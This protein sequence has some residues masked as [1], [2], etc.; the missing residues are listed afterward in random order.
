MLDIAASPEC[1]AGETSTIIGAAEQTFT[2][3]LLPGQYLL[4]MGN[5]RWSAW[6]RVLL[7]ISSETTA[8]VD[9]EIT[10]TLQPE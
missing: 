8:S 2:G 1:R 6:G 10:L 7:P 5:T 4:S 3:T 9:G